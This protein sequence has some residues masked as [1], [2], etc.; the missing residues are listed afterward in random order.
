M[1]ARSVGRSSDAARDDR[2]I[3]ERLRFSGHHHQ[4]S[5][6]RDIVSD[7]RNARVRRIGIEHHH[8]SCQPNPTPPLAQLTQV[9][10]RNVID[11]RFGFT[12]ETG[13]S[14][15]AISLSHSSADKTSLTGQLRSTV[16]IRTYERAGKNIKNRS[17]GRRLRTGTA[18]ARR[19]DFHVRTR[20]RRS[21]RHPGRHR[22]RQGFLRS[23]RAFPKFESLSGCLVGLVIGGP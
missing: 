6:W 13:G 19:K 11:S 22:G 12:V 20:G 1:G 14:R 17:W 5:R 9:G 16:E 3:P 2:R 10:G 21:R 15:P 8:H 23:R 7:R 18:L 4:D